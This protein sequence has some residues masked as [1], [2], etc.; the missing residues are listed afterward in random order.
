M[1]ERA[2]P[3][4]FVTNGSE[5]MMAVVR[6]GPPMPARMIHSKCLEMARQ[7]VQQARVLKLRQSSRELEAP[8]E[9][10][11]SYVDKSIDASRLILNVRVGKPAKY[12]FLRAGKFDKLSWSPTEDSFVVSM[13]SFLPGDIRLPGGFRYSCVDMASRNRSVLC[14]RRFRKHCSASWMPCYCSELL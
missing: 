13:S 8:H 10:H 11:F 6:A 9:P 12:I 7:H 2:W 5:E 1:D 3:A 14:A 4:C